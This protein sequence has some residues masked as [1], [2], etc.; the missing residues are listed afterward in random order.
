[1][2]CT[3][4]YLQVLIKFKNRYNIE[5]LYLD[6]YNYSYLLDQKRLNRYCYI[7]TCEGIL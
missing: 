6:L 7:G 4:V 2:F 3:T 1:M 5:Y